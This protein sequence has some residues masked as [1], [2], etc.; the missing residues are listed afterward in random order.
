MFRGDGIPVT[1][2]AGCNVG[3]I[4]SGNGAVYVTNGDR[5]YAVVL[6]ALGAVRVHAW[7]A[8]EG[9]WTD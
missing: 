1:F 2:D 4:G 7:N 5:D 3:T 9:A 8:V 6:T